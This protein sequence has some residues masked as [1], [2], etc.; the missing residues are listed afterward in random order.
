MSFKRTKGAGELKIISVDHVSTIMDE[1][2]KDLSILEVK[3]L[4]E[5]DYESPLYDDLFYGL[6]SSDSDLP[7][8]SYDDYYGNYGKR[9]RRADWEIH[10]EVPDEEP[11][12]KKKRKKNKKHNKKSKTIN[13]NDPQP[14]SKNASPLNPDYRPVNVAGLFPEESPSGIDDL[15]GNLI[16]NI[17]WPFLQREKPNECSD[18]IYE[19]LYR[20]GDERCVC[21]QMLQSDITP[22]AESAVCIT[23]SN[24]YGD[25]DIT[26]DSVCGL[27]K[28][29]EP[30]CYLNGCGDIISGWF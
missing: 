6:G 24:Q 11:P 3:G 7:E 12:K 1:V 4:K 9:K 19:F 20:E 15:H 26:V 10:A 28:F 22:A 23:K 27:D 21:D 30:I 18:R 29:D 14:E 8:I 2:F 25:T 16:I 13:S 5:T 17:T